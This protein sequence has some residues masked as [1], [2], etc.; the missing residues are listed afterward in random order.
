MTFQRDLDLALRARFT[1]LVVVTREEE[2][3]MQH[4]KAVCQA[5][6]RPLFTWNVADGYTPAAGPKARDALTAL[7]QVEQFPDEALVVL[8]DFHEFWGNPQIKR[9]LRN[10]AQRLRSV[11]KSLVVI[12]PAARLPEELIDTAVV[13]DFGLPGPEELRAL[14]DRFC[15]APGLNLSLTPL[16]CEKLVSAASGLSAAQVEREL[17][18]ALVEHGSLDDRHIAAMSQAKKQLLRDHEA[19]EYFPVSETCD[20]VGGLDVLKDWLRLRERAFTREAR[21]YGL[22]APKGIALLGIPGT[23][24]SLTA[25]IIGALWRM[26]LVRLDVGTLFGS[27]VGESEE[28]VRRALRVVEAIAPC[29]L[30]I[31][32]I[33]KALA[34]GSG[35]GGTSARVFA[36]LL[37]W[38][39]EK[40]APCFVVATANHIGSLPPELLRRGR[41]DEIFF[42]DL[43]TARE[44]RE[45]L[46]V[47]LVRRHRLPEDFDLAL[48][49]RASE[50]YVGAELEQAIV[51]GMHRGFGAGREFTTQDVLDSLH[52]LVPLSAS[53]REAIREMRAWLQQGR[54]QSATYHETREAVGRFVPLQFDDLLREN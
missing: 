23:G 1:L 8:A 45:I 53:H 30:M 49:A 17:A 18:R 54:A 19:L 41:F 24:K 29:I 51:D 5:T 14:L 12:T 52:R 25:R 20:D 26:P 43:P 13:I 47:H 32:E 46:A 33:E 38:M 9:K 27:L 42:L 40:R 4:V 36:T 21:D 48:L 37:T 31:D 35:D 15:S 50:G 44:R 39:Q 28:R 11:R 22:P 16:G 7:E 3:A 34:T 2:R 10:L 6:A